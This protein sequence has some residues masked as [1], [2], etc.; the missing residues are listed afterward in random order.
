MLAAQS[1]LS[2]GPV[3]W[4]ILE[5]DLQ[6][7]GVGSCSSFASCAYS[8]CTDP[9]WDDYDCHDNLCYHGRADAACAEAPNGFNLTD[10]AICLHGMRSFKCGAGAASVFVDYQKVP[11]NI[12]VAMLSSRPFRFGT[13]V[14][15]L[16]IYGLAVGH[17]ITAKVLGSN[18]MVK[19][20]A[21]AAYPLYL[22]HWPLFSYW[23]LLR[24]FLGVKRVDLEKA[25]NGAF[26]ITPWWE[27][28][29]FLPVITAL[30][31]FVAHVLNSYATVLFMNLFDH[32]YCCCTCVCG[33]QG[34]LMDEGGQN[35]LFTILDVVSG[36]TGADVDGTTLISHLGLDSFGASALVGI[37]GSRVPDVHLKAADVYE[38]ETVGDIAALIERRRCENNGK[39]VG[40]P[41][42]SEV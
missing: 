6:E 24:D 39:V 23:S 26:G 25:G 12:I 13:P 40:S 4:Q 20:L 5:Q 28:L 9:S 37:L 29:M 34:R 14:I 19:W 7:M 33:R 15:C 41:V 11:S 17:G 31:L 38:L 27:F 32:L 42:Q 35:A 18:F 30:A 22:F 1:Y 2:E 8:T 36:L 21:P 3:N 16:Y 10:G